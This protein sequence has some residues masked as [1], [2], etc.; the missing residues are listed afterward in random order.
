MHTGVAAV[1]LPGYCLLFVSLPG[2]NKCLWL[3]VRV[4]CRGHKLPGNTEYPSEQPCPG[5]RPDSEPWAQAA[6]ALCSRLGLL[7]QV[8]IPLGLR[9]DRG[10]QCSWEGGTAL[11]PVMG[12]K[13]LRGLPAGTAESCPSPKQGTGL[14]W[15]PSYVRVAW[16]R[17]SNSRSSRT[18][19]TVLGCAATTPQVPVP[20]G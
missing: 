14:D 16:H 5:P 9:G 2:T 12:P 17:D 20:I 10:W 8:P 18:A 11:R 4:G 19:C 13:A 7:W 3:G 15:L 6:A 1:L